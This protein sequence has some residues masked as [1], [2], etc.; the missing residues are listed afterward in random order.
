MTIDEKLGVETGLDELDKRHDLVGH[1]TDPAPRM[2]PPADRKT[3][4]DASVAP[5]QLE[6]DFSAN[7]ADMSR[8]IDA[9]TELLLGREMPDGTR[10]G[11]LAKAFE[12]VIGHLEK[13]RA[14]TDTMPAKH[15]ELADEYLKTQHDHLEFLTRI[16]K[17]EARQT[18]LEA[19]PAVKAGMPRA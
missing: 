4:R 6:L 11:G 16:V 13:I 17:L 8:K 14:T 10:A 7:I 2:V 5:P 15:A 12:D 1:D 18:L 19:A 3:P 9:L